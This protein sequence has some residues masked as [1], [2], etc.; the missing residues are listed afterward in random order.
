MQSGQWTESVGSEQKN[1]RSCKSERKT[2]VFSC[3]LPRQFEDKLRSFGDLCFHDQ[4]IKTTGTL[5]R[6]S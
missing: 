6:C 1:Y 3:D 2:N 5:E 4:E